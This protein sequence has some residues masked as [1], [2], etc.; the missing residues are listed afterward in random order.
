MYAQTLAE[1]CAL[2]TYLKPS[3]GYLASYKFVEELEYSAG[4]VRNVQLI[5]SLLEYIS[6]KCGKF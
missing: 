3:G 6:F 4:F 2:L 5:N 1:I